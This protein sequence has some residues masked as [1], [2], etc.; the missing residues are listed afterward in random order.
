MSQSSHLGVLFNRVTWV[1][2]SDMLSVYFSEM[3]LVPQSCHLGVLVCKDMV[4]P[5]VG[6]DQTSKISETFCLIKKKK[7]V[8][9]TFLP[10]PQN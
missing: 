9:R 4:V 5:G 3:S 8:K 2:F 6:T 10:N 1:H 7:Q